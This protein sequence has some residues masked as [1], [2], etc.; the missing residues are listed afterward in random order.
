ML[1]LLLVFHLL[2][3]CLVAKVKQFP[4]R[5]LGAL[6]NLL[7]EIRLSGFAEQFSHRYNPEEVL[8]K[9]RLFCPIFI[10]LMERNSNS[11]FP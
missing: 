10:F 3:W 8:I 4:P 1:L 6:A 2:P 5:L 11:S 9:N 7:Q